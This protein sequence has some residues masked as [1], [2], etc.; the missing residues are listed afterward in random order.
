MILTRPEGERQEI[1]LV[2]PPSPESASREELP[3]PVCPVG[4]VNNPQ[5]LGGEE[6]PLPGESPLDEGIRRIQ[7]MWS[8]PSEGGDR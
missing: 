2:A 4:E 3:K 1:D 7:E 6:P 8:A 5:G